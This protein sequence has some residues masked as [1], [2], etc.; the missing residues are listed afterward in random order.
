[1]GD[2]YDEFL[3]N[4]PIFGKLFHRAALMKLTRTMRELLV[5]GVSM[6]Q[7]LRLTTNIV[8]RNRIQRKLKELTDAVEE[9]GSFSRNLASGEVFPDTMV[10]KLQMAEEK[11]VVE[12]ALKELA[13]EFEADVDTL[14]TL[15]TKLLS[16]LML[17]IMSGVVFFLFVA[18]F[19][20]LTQLSSLAGN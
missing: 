11:G 16:P 4:L 14:A 17:V 10:W 15:I 20:P 19:M 3:L 6:V 18:T 7:T 9:G 12:D 5:N 8:G 1:M 2:S 13:V